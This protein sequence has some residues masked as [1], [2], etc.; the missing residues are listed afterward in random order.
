M[1][2]QDKAVLAKSRPSVSVLDYRREEL[3]D[4]LKERLASHP[5][6][7]SAYLFGSVVSGK[8]GAWSDLDLLIVTETDL[9]FIERPR[10]FWDLL[11]LDI[12]LDILVYTPAEFSRMK[13]T[14]TGFWKEFNRNHIKLN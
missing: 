7:I 6:A 2:Q 11:E 14:D 10:L 13:Q 5:E 12:P 3:I 9:P 1:T 4:L 8:A